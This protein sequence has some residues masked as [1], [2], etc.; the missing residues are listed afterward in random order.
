MLVSMAITL[1]MLFAIVQVFGR[2]GEGVNSAR[3]LIEL[4]GQLRQANH[5]LQGDL[6]SLT[7]RT[8]PWAR[9]DTGPG[10]F[11]YIEGP[12]VDHHASNIKDPDWAVDGHYDRDDVL[13][14]TV[15]SD[16]E[17]FV[18]E[19]GGV[20]LESHV[21][22]VIWFVQHMDLNENGSQ[23]PNEMMLVRKVFPIA[24]AAGDPP[25]RLG[26][27]YS[28]N[29]LTLRQNRVAHMK[30]VPY[31]YN[32]LDPLIHSEIKGEHVVLSGVISFDV[33]AF[34]PLAKEVDTGGGVYVSPQDA[35]Y[36]AG[37]TPN[38]Q[39]AYVNLGYD[40]NSDGLFGKTPTEI[41]NSLNSSRTNSI[42]GLVNTV[43]WDTW[44]YHYERDGINQDVIFS[45]GSGDTVTNALDQGTNGI[46][47][48]GMYGVDDPGERETSPPYPYPLR[49]LQI[50]IRVIE[51]DTQKIRQSTVVARFTPG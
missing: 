48:D 47:D 23:E 29:E 10:Y 18:A 21:A 25:I 4:A 37:G 45:G 39:G 36:V 33:K 5:L 27:G 22:E 38:R 30:D 6:D 51:S 17:P 35:S 28:L 32:P 9:A 49:G 13:I 16:E 2:M 19:V 43:A 20:M 15:Q 34:D 46:D 40:S 26:R 1:V 50:R 31:E 24:P 8:L 11:E 44:P 14:F 41:R 3:S 7:V 12:L 42:A